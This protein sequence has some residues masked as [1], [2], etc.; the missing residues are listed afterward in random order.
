MPLA[1]D[2]PITRL[3]ERLGPYARDSVDRGAAVALH[4]HAE[5]LTPEHVL[6]A[7]LRDEECGATRIVLHAFGDPE[8]ISIE[9]LALCQGIM[10][11]GS[12]RSL[13]F[14]VGGVDALESARR[15]ASERGDTLVD[16]AHLFA[17]AA[18]GLSAEVEE[19]L[20]SG[21]WSRRALEALAPERVA[22]RSPG[23]P[24]DG[25][26]FKFF[27]QEARRAL[28][29]ACR[30]ATRL[31]RDEISPAHLILGCLDTEKDLAEITG[32]PAG[33][34]SSLRGLD[35]DPTPRPLRRLPADASFVRMLEALTPPADTADL[36][37]W[38]LA[39]GGEEVRALLQRQR[40]T[41]QLLEHA[42]PS[43]GD[44]DLPTSAGSGSR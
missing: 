1:D 32:S 4:L 20:D 24:G 41:P 18:D 13:P 11:V 5:V 2:P 16:V 35:A 21:G 9:V 23:V 19:A 8:T 6:V 14:S 30:Q 36:L 15:S 44:P 40:I 28:G 43:F 22:E 27:A 38:I 25:P 26:L 3:L 7:L 17:A 12:E 10:V 31:G 29:S 42:G 33:L 34:R 39:H 37:A